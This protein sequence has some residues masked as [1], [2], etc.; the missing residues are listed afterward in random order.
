VHRIHSPGTRA[1]ACDTGGPVVY[2]LNDVQAD[3][4]GTGTSST[5][6]ASDPTKGIPTTGWYVNVHQQSTAAGT[7]AGIICATIPRSL[8]S[9]DAA[10]TPGPGGTAPSTLPP[11][12]TG[13][14]NGRAGRCRRYNVRQQH[15][16]ADLGARRRA[17]SGASIA[18]W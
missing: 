3:A 15:P 2:P 17:C 1:G 4:S 7:G 13:G 9:T 10:A 14:A 11:T 16:A 8:A 5:T 12:G 18:C 6:A